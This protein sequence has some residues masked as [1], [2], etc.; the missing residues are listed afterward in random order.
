[1]ANEIAKN[2][3][4]GLVKPGA[5]SLN[6]YDIANNLELI[7]GHISKVPAAGE[8]EYVDTDGNR[9]KRTV[10]YREGGLLANPVLRD[11]QHRIINADDTDLVAGERAENIAVAVS[12]EDRTTVRNAMMLEGHTADY[13]VSVDSGSDIKERTRMLAE[14][15][16]ND[17][18][19]IRD[20][21][22]Q[23]KYELMKKGIINQTQNQ[24]GYSDIF[25]EGSKPYVHELIGRP[26][27][28]CP[29]KVTIPLDEAAVGKLDYGDFIVISYPKE[30]RVDV[31]QVKEIGTDRETIRVDEDMSGI[32]LTPGNIEIYK[33]L[34]VSQDG[35]FYFAQEVEYQMDPKPMWT[36][37]DD[38]TAPMLYKP[39]SETTGSYAYSFR[40]PES[41]MGYL[42]EFQISAKAKGTPT[43]SC[44]IID[45]QDIGNFRNP[46]QARRLYENGDTTIDGEPKMHFF[47]KSRP[48]QLDPSKGESIVTFDFWNDDKDSYPVIDRK[49]EGRHR[50]RYAAIITGAYVDASNYASVRFIQSARTGG[51]LENNNTIYTYVRQ[52]D[53]SDTGAL[54]A[55]VELNNKDLY[56]SVTMHKKI[57]NEMKAVNRGLYTAQME[58]P[59][60]QAVSRARLTMRFRR[61]GGLWNAII[62]EPSVFATGKANHN[63]FDVDCYV[64]DPN[65][66]GTI[67]SAVSLGLA[68]G[69][70][71]P[72]ELRDPK[73]AADVRMRPDV[74]IGTSIVKADVTDNTRV[75][76][77]EPV[78]VHPHDM[79]Y[80]NGFAIRVKGKKVTIDPLTKERRVD[81]QQVIYLKPVA[82]IRDGHKDKNDEFSDRVVFEGEFLD[83]DGR[84]CFFNQLELQVYW[85]KQLFS[86]DNAIAETQMGIIR[87]LVF[88]VDS[89][90]RGGDGRGSRAQKLVAFQ[91]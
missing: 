79:V 71:K 67:R 60:G 72:L 19:S 16:G 68:E 85:E 32:D 57:R 22:Y 28:N 51:D 66:K 61:E 64:D 12:R 46:E 26:T 52:D 78:F 25:R 9:K 41:K 63:A 4:M 91:K 10:V 81:A 75:A 14:S 42:T 40:I 82:V 2:F 8:E 65:R 44:Y 59:E 76:P 58:N 90:E 50:V 27:A 80:R 37:L 69:I 53:S 23:L 83:K 13:F 54:Q 84:S 3:N 73:L 55:S 29:D 30:Q 87:D 18:A 11:Y 24:F 34:G 38:D 86:E 33:T 39:I 35:S 45:E 21:L 88:S 5:T 36:G 17:I 15:Y 89:S 31:R 47:A 70:H 20:E 48:V 77:A 6:M 62:D 43:L 7:H 56:Y 1:M 49:D 74:I